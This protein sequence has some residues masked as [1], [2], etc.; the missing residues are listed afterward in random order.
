MARL[1]IG[2]F[3]LATFFIP[4]AVADEQT[5][6]VQEELRKRHLYFGD[7]DGR[8]SAELAGAL[9]RYQE[10]KGFAVTGQ[11]DP[12]TVNSLAA[13]AP[14]L[15]SATAQR[16]AQLPDVPVLRSDAARPVTEPEADPTTE[17]SASPSPAVPAPAESP[18]RAQDLAP[19]RV[20]KLVEDYLRDAETDNVRAQTRYYADR[21]NYFDD[22]EVPRR[23]IEHDTRR[24]SKEWPVRK[25]MLTK[26]VT[27]AAGST[28][29]ETTVE[30]EIAYSTKKG[31][32]T[33]TGKTTNFWTLRA[34]RDD[35]KIVAIREERVR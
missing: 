35:L 2:L 3:F 7:I 16:P 26:P 28:D 6:R 23:F 12:D 32:L 29:N 15:A 21:V 31:N 19:E 8:T 25:Y 30:F 24:Y 22:G 20:Q 5:R 10:R 17:E 27:F 11:I 1:L 13:A 33:A 14:M 34:D 18:A 4:S 9:R